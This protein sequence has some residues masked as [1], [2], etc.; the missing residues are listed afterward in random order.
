MPQE[1]VALEN[2]G[3]QLSFTSRTVSEA[4]PIKEFA[5]EWRTPPG[6]GDSTWTRNRFDQG[7]WYE[8]WGFGYTQRF[9][10]QLR[11]NEATTDLYYRDENDLDPPT[12]RV[13]VLLEISQLR[14]QGIKL[15]RRWQWSS[16]FFAQAD[17][18]LLSASDFQ[19][20]ILA[21][22]LGSDNEFFSGSARLD[23]R[24]SEDLLL[25]H[26]F[27]PPEGRGIALDFNIGYAGTHRSASL[28]VQD[29]YSAIE[30]EQ[31]PHTFGAFDSVDRE[32][33]HAVQLNPLFTGKRLLEDYRQRMPVYATAHYA[34][35]RASVDWA[36]D[37]ELFDGDLRYR[38]GLRWD[39][40]P[41][42]PYLGY[43][44]V[45][46]Q[47]LLQLGD[48]RGFWHFQLG[49]DSADWESAHSLTLAFGF[50]APIF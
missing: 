38:P 11:Y 1:S 34:E 32:V 43:E 44:V 14:A 5:D 31:A 15:K 35:H 8:D 18:S 4:L 42:N 2:N 9:D 19:D 46:G 16:G 6:K 33:A 12:G 22:E 39:Q 50:S 13:P 3:I 30:W 41:G 24:Y 40:L 36:L 23:Y 28:V 47:W 21:G 20:G 10:Y 25:E 27:E 7:V 48:D 29:L 45:D 49:S 37:L 17:L 26:Q